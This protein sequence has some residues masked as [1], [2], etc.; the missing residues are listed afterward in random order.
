MWADIRAWFKEECEQW[1]QGFI[2]DLPKERARRL[3]LVIRHAWSMWQTLNLPKNLAKGSWRGDD[4]FDQMQQLKREVEELH[5]A[6]WEWECGN[7][8]VDRVI[9][10]AADVSVFSAMVADT[11]KNNA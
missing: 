7:G 1:W 10:E 5:A 11:V 9:S 6:I 2:D 3:I 4:H 8:S